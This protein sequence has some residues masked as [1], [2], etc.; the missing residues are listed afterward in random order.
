MTRKV[1]G[2][3]KHCQFDRV[4][5]IDFALSIGIVQHLVDEVIVQRSDIAQKF[6]AHVCCIRV[7]SG[8]SR[9]HSHIEKSCN[10]SEQSATCVGHASI[11]MT[12]TSLRPL[13]PRGD[14]TRELAVAETSVDWFADLISRVFVATYCRRLPKGNVVKVTLRSTQGALR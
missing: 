7:A 6:V 14:D 5:R 4:S 1:H 2:L 10:N 13:F 12:R 8:Y 9:H 11:V 3:S